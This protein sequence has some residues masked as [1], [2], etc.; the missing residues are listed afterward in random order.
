MITCKECLD[1]LYP[2][3]PK[4]RSGKYRLCSCDYC[5]KPTDLRELEA[6]TL[7]TLPIE[8]QGVYIVPEYYREFQQVKLRCE[9]FEKKLTEHLNRKTNKYRNYI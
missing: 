5:A 8:P 7:E 3:D 2:H 6:T 9:H 1:K 4:V